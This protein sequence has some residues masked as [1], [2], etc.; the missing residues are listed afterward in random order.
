MES[1]QCISQVWTVNDDLR[2]H[3]PVGY[4]HATVRLNNLDPIIGVVIM[5]RSDHDSHTISD[6]FGSHGND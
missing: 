2:E 4:E 3:F 1:P 5:T 6:S